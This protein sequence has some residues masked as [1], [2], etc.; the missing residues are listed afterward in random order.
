MKMNLIISTCLGL[1]ACGGKYVVKSFPADAKLYIKDIRT[2]EKKLV[3]NTPTSIEEDPRLGEVFFVVIEKENYK[4]KEIMLK[5]NEGESL[6]VSAKLDP[7]IQDTGSEGAVAKKDDEQK[8]QQG[9][10]PEEKPKDWQKEMDDMKMRIALLEN[11]TSFYKDAL[12]SPR[13]A[14]GMP[15]HDRDR[16]ETVVGNIFKAQQSIMKGKY[17]EALRSID[18]ATQMDEYATNAWLLKGSVKYLLKD[19]QGA[20]IA[21][22]RTLKLDPYNKVAFKYLNNV[23]KVLKVN[24]LAEN[25]ADLR[26]PANTL[27]IDQRRRPIQTK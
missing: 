8:P 4:P 9:G 11:T 19:F 20:R 24:P 27:E 13:L 12:F 16:S 14:G 17:D 26:Q 6:T 10:K 1:T 2:N 5:V 21:W 3:G 7:F 18:T 23:Y 15:A 25:A 22:E